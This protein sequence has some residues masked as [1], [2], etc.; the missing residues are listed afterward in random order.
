[1]IMFTHSGSFLFITDLKNYVHFLKVMYESCKNF[2]I[3]TIIVL[4]LNLLGELSKD[5]TAVI[6]FYRD[7]K[8]QNICMFHLLQVNIFLQ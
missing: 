2:P 3:I 7:V 8:F 4:Y 5:I 6:L 1:M